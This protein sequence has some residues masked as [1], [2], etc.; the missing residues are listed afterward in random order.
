MKIIKTAFEPDHQE[1]EKA[2]SNT[3]RQSEGI[4]EGIA[5]ISFQVSESGFEIIFKHGRLVVMDSGSMNMPVWNQLSYRV[6][7]SHR[8]ENCAELDN[9][10]A[11]DPPS[12]SSGKNYTGE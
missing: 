11:V 1:K 8:E 4:D 5:F 3:D 7:R 9:E 6:L 12:V 10:C 2:G